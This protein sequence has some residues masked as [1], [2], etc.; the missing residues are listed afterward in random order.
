DGPQAGRKLAPPLAVSPSKKFWRAAS[1][2]SGA[3]K[4][5]RAPKTRPKRPRTRTLYYPPARFCTGPTADS[6][7]PA[8]LAVLFDQLVGAGDQLRRD[9][10]PDNSGGFE[11]DDQLEFDWLQH[12]KV[13]W[14]RPL[15]NTAS[16]EANLTIGILVTG[17]VA[18]QTTGDYR[19]PI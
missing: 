10:Q 18:D 3:P 19:L 7:T 14:L 16:I 11:V 9:F 17:T 6:C 1:L 5:F 13:G 8:K 4:T 2:H 12:R 15:E